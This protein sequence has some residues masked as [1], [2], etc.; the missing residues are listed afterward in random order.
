MFSKKFSIEFHSKFKNQ[1]S[2]KLR[3]KLY[4]VRIH[5]MNRKIVFPKVMCTQHPDSASR[6]I[7]TQEE[8]EEAIE[9]AQVFGCDEYMPDYEGKATPYHQ[10]VQIV[11]KFIEETDLIPGKDIFITPRAPSAAQENRFRQL[12]TASR[13]SLKLSSIW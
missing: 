9:A 13:K 7:S 3:S 8:P 6:Y 4:A 12:M 1:F 5:F 2:S 11:S 10:N